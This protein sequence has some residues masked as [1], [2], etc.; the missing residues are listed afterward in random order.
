MILD[1]SSINEKL[2]KF[3]E[4]IQHPVFDIHEA[5]LIICIE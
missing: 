5:E 3:S 4:C 2:F 1:K